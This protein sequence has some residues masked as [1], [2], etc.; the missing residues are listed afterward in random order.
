[1]GPDFS[2]GLL[3]QVGRAFE[4]LTV[5]ETWRQVKPQVLQYLS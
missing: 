3:L 4:K 5:D 2:E 1:L